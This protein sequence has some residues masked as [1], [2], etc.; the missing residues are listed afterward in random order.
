MQENGP[1]PEHESFL[2]SFFKPE[3]R[4]EIEEIEQP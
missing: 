4:E 3:L 1:H 2:R